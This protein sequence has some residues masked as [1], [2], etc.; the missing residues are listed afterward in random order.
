MCA[1]AE[2]ALLR[3]LL[4]TPG[5]AKEAEGEAAGGR[6]KRRAGAP[7]QAEDPAETAKKA[8]L[9]RT[10]PEKIRS[11]RAI[12][13]M[14]RPDW[15]LLVFAYASL[16]VAAAGDTTIPFL[17]GQLI[18]AIAINRDPDKFTTYMLLLVL[19]AVVTG[20]FTGFR[21]STFIVIGGRF[22]VRSP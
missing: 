3:W 22:S 7:K 16:V 18:D 8:Y 2:H 20:V 13:A 9:E 4:R 17:Y 14:V 10:Q 6:R 11:V 5:A 1:C 12:L 21:G 19:T 15:H